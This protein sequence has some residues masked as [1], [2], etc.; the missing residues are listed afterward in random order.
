M[1]AT[2]RQKHQSNLLRS[3][4]KLRLQQRFPAKAET[5]VSISKIHGSS[6]SLEIS[7]TPSPLLLNN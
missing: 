6:K 4:S 7:N 1:P 5:H 2:C 3:L